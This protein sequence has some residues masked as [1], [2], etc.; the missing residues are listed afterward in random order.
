MVQTFTRALVAQLQHIAACNALHPVE[1]RMALWLLR[2]HDQAEDDVLLVTQ[3]AMAELLGVHRP[4]VT[5]VAAKLKDAGAI[6]STRRGV[7]EV[8]RR[9]LEATTCQCYE[10]ISSRLDRI[11][12]P[13]KV[14]SAVPAR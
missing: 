7:V 11:V 8:D 5:L 10:A 2:L 14:P 6:R 13:R 9:R 4:T 12:P 1:Q 3:E